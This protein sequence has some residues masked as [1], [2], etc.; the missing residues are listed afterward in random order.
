MSLRKAAVRSARV[1]LRAWASCSLELNEEGNRWCPSDELTTLQDVNGDETSHEF[2]IYIDGSATMTEKWPREAACASLGLAALH[3]SAGGQ[4]TWCGSLSAPIQFGST[5]TDVLGATRL[6]N[7]AAE[8]T[9]LLAALEWRVTLPG[10]VTTRI[11]SDSR[12]SIDLVEQ[13]ARVSTNVA[14]VQQCRQVLKV[15]RAFASTVM[16][17]T[18]SRQGLLGDEI[19]DALAKAAANGIAR[20]EGSMCKW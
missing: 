6:T 8:L 2:V 10:Q 9:A 4:V 13:R 17:H 19:A 14:Q 11:V 3:R 7:N 20:P 12:V 5:G 15:C 16:I 1:R 18:Y